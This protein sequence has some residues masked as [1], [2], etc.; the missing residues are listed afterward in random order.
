MDAF[1]NGVLAFARTTTDRVG[2]QLLADFGT[3]QAAQKTDGSLV[4]Q[5]DRW[6][7]EQLQAAIA[8][9]FPDHGILSEEAQ[10]TFPN[11]DWCWAIDPVD[12]T[13]NFTRGIPIWGISMGLLYRGVPVFG[14]V[15][16]PG[17]GQTF[18]GFW[19]GDSGLSGPTGAFCNDHPIRTSADAPS[20]NH[21]FNLCARSTSL[22][23]QPFPCKLRMV[24]VCTYS[25]LLV[26]TG[27]ALGAEEATPK[28]WDLAA[29]WPI[30]QA[31]GGSSLPLTPEAIFPLVVGQDYGQT[32]YPSLVVGR[33]DL[34]PVFRPLVAEIADRVLAAQQ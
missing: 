6:A 28:V 7:D 5:A 33:A 16:F 9:R 21:L 17:L 23:A 12:G 11:R 19:Y 34:V 25:F 2:R 10:H 8:Q 14:L 31:A 20:S 24:G 26:A 30:L 4:T 3:V 13:T 15:H 29:V 22:A 1:W 27:A 32:S 18:H